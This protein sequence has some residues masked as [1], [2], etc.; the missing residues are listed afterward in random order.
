M[1][2]T[3]LR[4]FVSL[5][6]SLLL[7]LALL[8]ALLYPLSKIRS[9]HLAAPKR[10][11]LDRITLKRAAPA[12]KPHPRPK[13][14]RP[15]PPPEAAPPS[16]PTPAPIHRP[17]PAPLHKKRPIHHRKH[18][19]RTHPRTPPK[20]VHTP[21]PKPTPPAPHTPAPAAA[22][23]PR[24]RQD[25]AARTLE[26]VLPRIVAAIEAAKYYPRMARRLHREGRVEVSFVLER[27]GSVHDIAAQTPY[28]LLKRAAIET[29]HRAEVHFPHPERRLTIR[30]PIV[31]RL[32]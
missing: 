20:S 5:F 17:R 26:A 29:I 10:I 2:R 24:V 14:P 30:V 3:S 25:A 4:H 18:H 6:G 19:R 8:G 22:P 32:K 12:P 31:Y 27:D 15:A 23:T 9:A 21:P 13:P 28:R 16:P 7:H 1:S 11:S